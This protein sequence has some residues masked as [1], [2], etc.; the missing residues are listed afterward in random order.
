MKNG[1]AW[2][3]GAK[4]LWKYCTTKHCKEML[5][6][7]RLL[8]DRGWP[9]EKVLACLY[10]LGNHAE[11]HY[12][13]LRIPKKHGGTRLLLAPDP[14]LKQVQ[15]NILHH[16]LEGFAPAGCATAY[17]K[18]SSAIANA[19]LHEGKPLLLKLDIEDFFGSIT[20]PMVLRY[21]F[22]AR[23]FPPPVGALLASLCCYLDC[24][25]QGAP[26]SP[27]LSNLV[28][29]PFDRHMAEWCQE[30]GIFYTR[31]CDDMAFSGNFDAGEVKRKAY[32][33]L[34]A[35]GLEPN[36]K[37]ERVLPKGA[38]QTV[39]GLVVNEKA[40]PTKDYR[41]KLRQELYYCQRFGTEGHLKRIGSQASLPDGG[42]GTRRYLQSLLGKVNY[43][44]ETRPDDL[45]LWQARE[46]LTGCLA[47]ES[48]YLVK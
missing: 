6:S 46:W 28:M 12:E 29:G 22:P 38:R 23:Y 41:R 17:H 33:F 26:T 2:Q 9:E 37:K 13:K 15:K 47:K 45:W 8:G 11:G 34:R 16:V 1:Q 7:F 18:G 40:Q 14:L 5:L 20:F 43:V 30:R 32:G 4:S 10:A 44:L 24:L 42:A 31:Y 36:R 21:G 27:A 39:T 25:P 35:M 19:K 3:Q 48:A